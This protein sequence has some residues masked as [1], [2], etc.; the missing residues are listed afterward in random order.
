MDN[1]IHFHDVQSTLRINLY[2]Q[3]IVVI[4]NNRFLAIAKGS[5][6]LVRYPVVH[7]PNNACVGGIAI[8]VTGERLG[9]WLE[10]HSGA[11]IWEGRARG[12][13]GR[14]EGGLT[15]RPAT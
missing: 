15:G 12:R 11:N 9:Q 8:A 10:G 13:E 4:C 1:K 2:A 3:L 14:R 7:I 5:I 6:P